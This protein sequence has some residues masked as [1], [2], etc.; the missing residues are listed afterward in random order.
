MMQALLESYVAWVPFRRPS[1]AE[2][3]RSI[4]YE[5]AEV[6]TDASDLTVCV[7]RIDPSH[8]VTAVFQSACFCAVV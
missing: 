8:L 7:L 2:R 5:A 3:N 6:L 1:G 4:G